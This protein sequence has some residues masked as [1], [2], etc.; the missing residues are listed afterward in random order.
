L[1]LLCYQSIYRLGYRLDIWGSI[2]GRGNDEIFS[3]HH[4]IKTGTGAHP[5]PYPMGTGGSYPWGK[6]AG[7]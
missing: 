2:P 5:V 6:A 1:S 7:S 4:H 3:L